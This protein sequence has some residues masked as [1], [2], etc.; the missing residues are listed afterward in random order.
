MC[1]PEF[2]GEEEVQ[3]DSEHQGQHGSQPPESTSSSEK[4]SD[5]DSHS[6]GDPFKGEDDSKNSDAPKPEKK[7]AEGGEDV[8][9]PSE[10]GDPV[11]KD[12]SSDKGEELS[13]SDDE[14]EGG[15]STYR[16]KPRR[17]MASSVLGSSTTGADHGKIDPDDHDADPGTSIDKNP[18]S[19]NRRPPM[20]LLKEKLVKEHKDNKE[21]RNDGRLDEGVA[22]GKKD[23]PHLARADKAAEILGYGGM[24]AGAVGNVIMP[25]FGY[26]GLAFGNKDFS[27]KFLEDDKGKMTSGIA[28]FTASALGFGASSI[29]AATSMYRESRTKSRYA[30]GIAKTNAASGFMGMIGGGAGMAASLTGLLTKAPKGS[31]EAVDAGK[32]AGGEGIVKGVMDAIS[33]GL[34][35]KAARDERNAHRS[36]SGDADRISGN[37]SGQDILDAR[38]EI[39]RAKGTNDKDAL[40]A[41]KKRR[42]TAKAKKYAMRQ[43]ATIHAA[44]GNES[45][46][47][48]GALI[49]GALSG[50]GSILSG[51]SNI[52]GGGMIGNVLKYIGAAS[53]GIGFLAKTIGKFVDKKKAGN[54][55]KAL[56]TDKHRIVDEYVDEKASRIKTEA[57]GVKLTDEEK[58]KYG[59]T[60]LSNITLDEAK[61]IAVMRLGVEIRDTD[62]YGLSSEGYEEAFKILTEK[63]AK[64][65]LKSEDADKH[66]MLNALG[67]SDDATLEDVKAALGGDIK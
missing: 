67:L 45:R 65:I 12:G 4:N 38:E 2:S 52:L 19:P 24:A 33:G 5:H 34:D 39:R 10:D 16:R 23:S 27:D 25:G 3:S 20:G 11:I 43:A 37:S 48:I 14:S 44:R 7:D 31:Q 1:G 58:A 64:N 21:Q 63:R 41:A 9:K 40:K 53:S 50:L 35:F 8:A 62:A 54:E 66:N 28:G 29:K 59:I 56:E 47:G 18:I 49:G 61:I 26:G 30:K 17:I 46:K 32:A 13:Q 15:S 60:D 51:V 22:V 6:G 57:E 55:K 36:I 42:H